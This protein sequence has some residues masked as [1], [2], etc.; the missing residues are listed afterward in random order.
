[1][2]MQTKKSR[3]S[4]A[5]IDQIL[6]NNQQLTEQVNSLQAQ[7]NWFKR[8][9]FGHKSE[10]LRYIDNPDQAQLDMGDQPFEKP[11]V[12]TEEIKPYQRRKK[13]ARAGSPDDSGLRFDEKDV[14][15]KR[16]DLPCPELEGP[17]A[18]EYEIIGSR[19][20]YRLAQRQSDYVILKYVRKVVKHHSTKQV[21]TAPAAA[22]IFD[23]N[24][25][26]VSF[27]VGLLVNKFLYH[28]PLYR[29]H[30]RLERSGITLAR[31]TLTN[32]SH[33]AIALLTPI[34]DAQLENVLR[35]HVLAMDETPIKAGNR[36][37]GKLHQG[38]YLPVYGD[39][40]EMVFNYSPSKSKA[41]I[42]A[43]LSGFS[44]TLLTD[45]NVA[46][47][48]YV[49]KTQHAVHAG[50]WSHSRRYFERAC[51]AEPVAS[52]H[53]LELIARLYHEDG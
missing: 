27:I 32:I 17:S 34:V 46:Y 10:K 5:D 4:D 26:D 9:I 47:E 31:A 51:E 41:Q 30:Q 2:A 37:K 48:H 36:K 53:A 39:Q 16:I 24:Q 19:V 42:E 12:E 13:K 3:Y 1:M 38:Y 29:Q 50:C 6:L 18:D 52:R 21:T 14:D 28:Q 35:S 33:R 11:A 7:L 40:D 8:Q 44:G 49:R 15:I 23:R 45:G 22:G 43:V 20:D 25:F